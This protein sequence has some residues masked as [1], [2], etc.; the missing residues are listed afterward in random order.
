MIKNRAKSGKF[1]NK[2]EAGKRNK[3]IKIR[4]TENTKKVFKKAAKIN[5]VSI[6]DLIHI[7]VQ[8]YLSSRY[9]LPGINQKKIDNIFNIH[10]D[11][12]PGAR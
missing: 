2:S 10:P 4:V 8:K 12:D 7:S 6:S 1:S 3:I 11:Q 5:G 9:P